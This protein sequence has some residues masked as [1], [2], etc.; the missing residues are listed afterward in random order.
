MLNRITNTIFAGLAHAAATLLLAL[1]SFVTAAAAPETLPPNASCISQGCHEDLKEPDYLHG[2][3]NMNQ[4]EPCHVPVDNKHE[5]TAR[6]TG[7][8][9]CFICHEAEAKKDV[10]HPPF[11]ADCTVCHD[12]HS[13]DVRYFVKGGGGAESCQ[14]CHTDVR[15][16]LSFVHGPVAMGECLACHTPHQSDHEGLLISSRQELCMGCHIDV[17]QNLA[18]AVSVHKPVQESCEGC[19]SAHGGSTQFFLPEEGQDLCKGCHED[20]LKQVNEFEFTH[21]PMVE[22]KTCQNCHQAHSSNQEHLLQSNVGTLCLGCHNQEIQGQNESIDNV[23]AQIQSAQFLHGPL[24][25]DNCSACHAA[26]GSDNPQILDQ[27]F[28]AEFYTPYEEGKYDLCFACHDQ[29]LVLQETTTETGFRNGTRNLH[30]VHVN[31][32][33]GRSC[34]ACH[35]EHASNQPKHIR[36]EVPF[37][38]WTMKTEFTMTDTGGTCS[39]GCHVPY[40]YDRENPI[41]NH[42][43]SPQP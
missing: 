14:T 23:A 22:G 24:R 33:K 27:P 29:A 37:G 2:P 5:F 32:E 25:Q 8:D 31:R 21:H 35:H 9:L 7:R 12:P 17:E 6:A 26:H 18:G 10:L 34:R 20:F 11:E 3:L 28:P 41:D 30:F 19:H 1:P 4:C 40:K 13:S 16:G 43:A 15:E 42:A 36:S 39:T 38:R